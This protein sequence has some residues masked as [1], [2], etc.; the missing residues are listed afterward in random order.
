MSKITAKISIIALVS[1]PFVLLAAE[2]HN[3]KH[4]EKSSVPAKTSIKHK[5]HVHGMAKLD[6]TIEG[7]KASFEFEIPGMDAFGFETEAKS[8]E[9]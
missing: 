1:F 4:E 9:Q 7:K 6:V 3:H 8:P 2:G 5:A